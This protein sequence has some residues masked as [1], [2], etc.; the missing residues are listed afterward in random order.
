MAGPPPASGAPTVIEVGRGARR[1]RVIRVDDAGQRRIG[2]V[3]A[4]RDAALGYGDRQLRG[5]KHQGGPGD[6][7]C[8]ARDQERA[9]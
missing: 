5:L 2:S 8:D 4:R 6:D 1:R 9:E 3:V 7:H